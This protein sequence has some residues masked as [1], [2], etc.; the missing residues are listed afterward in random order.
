M[1][2]WILLFL[3]AVGAGTASAATPAQVSRLT[4]FPVSYASYYSVH[5]EKLA[6]GLGRG[7]GDTVV[8]LGGGPGGTS[9]E[10]GENGYTRLFTDKILTL[11][12]TNATVRL[13]S[14]SFATSTVGSSLVDGGQFTFNNVRIN[15]YTTADNL[16][17]LNVGTANIKTLSLFGYEFPKCSGAMEWV[18]L[19]FD[20]NKDECSWYLHC[21]DDGNGSLS[22]QCT[23]K[24]H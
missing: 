19:K 21:T 6:I 16:K 22:S 10:V 5:A 13:L 8:D 2:K 23:H 11:S 14:S 24:D 7:G 18:L 17:N 20:P 12:G 4:Y 3:V 15:A 9:L 1:K